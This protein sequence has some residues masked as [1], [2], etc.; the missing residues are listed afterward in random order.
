MKQFVFGLATVIILGL[1]GYYTFKATTGFL[2]KQSPSP[3]A[4]PSATISPTPTPTS[5]SRP[6]P[7]PTTNPAKSYVPTTKG[8]VV[9]G[10]STAKTITTTTTTSSHLTLTLIKTS[11][12]QTYVSEIKDITGPLTLRYFLKDGYK[13]SVNAW[14]SNGEEALSQREISG[15]GELMR[16]EGLSYLKLQTQP[17]SCSDTSDTWLTITAER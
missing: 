6:T 11:A 7:T 9:K 10:A 5:T 15:S 16:I 3:S 4:S 8:G 12:C 2:Q 1:T 13:A 17:A 14:K